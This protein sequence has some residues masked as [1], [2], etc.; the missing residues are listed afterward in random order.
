MHWACACSGQRGWVLLVISFARR[1]NE[2]AAGVQAGGMAL[3]VIVRRSRNRVGQ[4]RGFG[5]VDPVDSEAWARRSFRL[6]AAGGIH[7]HG[8]SRSF[9][10][11]ARTKAGHWSSRSMA[12]GAMELGG[13]AA[14][15]ATPAGRGARRRGLVAPAT[16]AMAAGAGARG[17]PLLGRLGD[18]HGTCSGIGGNLARRHGHVAEGARAK[19][20]HGE[21]TA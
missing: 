10:T 1:R 14:E 8:C 6:E 12:S 5:E 13:R 21:A 3:V 15:G 9:V 19:L 17:A 16:G 20:L 2:G 4:R 7:G 11:G 18:D